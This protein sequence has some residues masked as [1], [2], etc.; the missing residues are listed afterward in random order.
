MLT[1]EYQALVDEAAKMPPYGMQALFLAA[2]AGGSYN[3][4]VQHIA[5]NYCTAEYFP[6]EQDRQDVAALAVLSA[7]RQRM[8][9]KMWDK[10]V[11]DIVGELLG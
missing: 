10:A 9:D 5:K 6:S 11:D 3:D 2:Y 1:K 4:V 8:M 7:A